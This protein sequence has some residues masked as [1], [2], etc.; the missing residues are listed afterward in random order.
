MQ[1]QDEETVHRRGDSGVAGRNSSTSASEGTYMSRW[2]RLVTGAVLVVV[3]GACGGGP[4]N[5]PNTQEKPKAITGSFPVAADRKLAIDCAGTGKPTIVLEVGF[6]AAGTRGDWTMKPL[7]DQLVSRYRV[8]NYDRANLGASDPAPKPRTTGEI[9]DD[10]A[11]LLKSAQVPGPY[12]LVGG[13]AGGLYVQHFAA[14]HSDNVVAV[15]A[16]NPEQPVDEFLAKASALFTKAE[17]AAEMAYARGTSP[18]NSQGIDL[19]TS[20]KQIKDDGPVPVPL[21]IMRSIN[22]CPPDDATCNKLV[23]VHPAIDKNRV[24]A[25]AD[26]GKFFL[27]DA[28]HD[29]YLRHADKVIAE[30][31]RLA[32]A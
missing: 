2:M 17:K 7:R 15:L 11:A 23:D 30:I 25:A 14:R 1:N 27:L 4:A 8:C 28:P 16:L 21:S 10:L 12:V 31:H 22:D 13:S 18:A 24:A 32:Q 20:A 3:V 29:I 26:G 9:A 5:Q 6:D 19:L